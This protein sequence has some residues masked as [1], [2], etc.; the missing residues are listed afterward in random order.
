MI[1][2][3]LVQC[4]SWTVPEEDGNSAEGVTGN[5]EGLGPS[6]W[7]NHFESVLYHQITSFRQW[8][9]HEPKTH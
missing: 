2:S 5:E 8:T 1:P 9:H 7:S 6:P 3:I 4:K